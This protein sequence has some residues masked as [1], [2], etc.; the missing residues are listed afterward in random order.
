MQIACNPSLV[1]LVQADISI[2]DASLALVD[3]ILRLC[4]PA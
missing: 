3:M 1:F 4:K 2:Q